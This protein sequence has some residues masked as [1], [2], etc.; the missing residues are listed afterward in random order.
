M[1]APVPPTSCSRTGSRSRDARPGQVWCNGSVLLRIESR[2]GSVPKARHW[3][4]D[5]TRT[6]GMS[7]GSVA[8]VELLTSELVTNAVRHG[9][10]EAI[11]VRVESTRTTCTVAVTD[12]GDAL[13]V[14]RSSGPHVPG[15]HGMR[16]VER[17]AARW[18]VRP[19]R[20]GGKTVWFTVPLE[21]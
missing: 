14:V 11:T 7:P 9:S 1:S 19:E 4:N 15:G 17:L 2:R 13:P 20:G 18:G 21:G 12:A 5:Q 3:V 10:S 8:T 6:L 16:L